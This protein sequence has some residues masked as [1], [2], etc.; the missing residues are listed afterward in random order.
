MPSDSDLIRYVETSLFNK[1]FKLMQNALKYKDLSN[2]S[3]L[4]TYMSHYIKSTII[5][6]IY[7]NRKKQCTAVVFVKK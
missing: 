2:R 1:N 3:K 4:E 5:P 6:K 7:D